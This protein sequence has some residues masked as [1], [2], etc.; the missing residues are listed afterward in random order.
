MSY[1]ELAIAAI[2]RPPCHDR[3]TVARASSAMLRLTIS[4]DLG[5]DLSLSQKRVRAF[6]GT[7]DDSGSL[8]FSPSRDGDGLTVYNLGKQGIV[9]IR[10][11]KLPGV[12]MPTEQTDLPHKWRGEFL[13]LDLS[14][15]I[16]ARRMC[17]GA[18]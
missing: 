18:S 13:V 7:D 5:A 6:V 4:G 12:V 11:D 3:V 14:P 17:G 15:L 9:C 1:V 2:G 8:I 16:P 10:A